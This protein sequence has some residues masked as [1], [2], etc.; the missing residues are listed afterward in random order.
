MSFANE[1]KWLEFL[2]NIL[3]ISIKIE[4]ESSSEIIGQ[5]KEMK[6]KKEEEKK[7]NKD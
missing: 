7:K 4:Y 2:T 3:K 6:K 5:Q 1:G